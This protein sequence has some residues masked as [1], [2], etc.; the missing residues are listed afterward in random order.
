MSAPAEQQ[1]DPTGLQSLAYRYLPILAWLPAYNRAQLMPD[2]VAALTVWA[3]LVPEAMAYAT[4]AGVPLE[5]GLY[6]AILPLFLYA[7]F[8]TSRQLI[9]G[10]SSTVAILSAATIAPL[11]D[12]TEEF[13]AL[14][15][16]L[17][18]LVGVILVVAG[19]A[20]MGWV[21]QFMAKP[22]LEG[23]VIGLALVVLVGQ[24]DKLV[25][26]DAEGDNFWQEAWDLVNSLGN[27]HLET[28]VIGVGSLVLLFTLA[29]FVP[30][31]PGALITVFLG[32]VISASLNLEDEGVH[33]VGDIPSGLPPFGLP[34]GI[35][36]TDIQNLL[37][38]AFGIVLV[39]YAES[40]A[41]AQSYAT[42]Y[43]YAV[44]PNQ[45]LIALGL[46]NAGA[47][48]SQGF[49]VD[50]SLSRT[51]A[52]DSAGQKTQMSSLINGALVIVTVLALTALFQDLPEAVLGAI[53][54]HAVWHL[55][56][57]KKLR[58]IYNVS[59]AD[60]WLAAICMLGV[61]TFDILA[62]LIIA[63]AVSL[64]VLIYRASRP[65]IPVLGKDPDE[66]VYRS[67]A[68]HPESE[69]YTGLIIF[70]LDAEL[71]FANATYFRDRV[72]EQRATADPPARAILVD[73]E[74]IHDLD[75]TAAEML[76]ELASELADDGIELLFA[77]VHQ[78]VRE[79]MQRSGVEDAVGPDHIYPTIQDGVDDFLTRHPEAGGR[80]RPATR[81]T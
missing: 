42:K 49:V 44:D 47:A 1:A 72:R 76:K 54:V 69:T 22:V 12:G 29:R 58:A 60:F 4:I 17:A 68:R 45:E 55:I 81:D 11:A 57:L 20:R 67:I 7:I 46:S 16:A 3:L 35:S 19:V 5:A 78:T 66:N 71:F 38:G 79:M 13:I 80:D 75:I 34:D 51:A 59:K 52:A 39:A 65:G 63:V 64:L 74:A 10:P 24:A 37:P 40:L 41:I 36:L 25:G 28:A 50:G 48:V 18:I 9:T 73:A 26:V 70:R 62:G 33:I 21:S 77:R 6:A 2:A 23:F 31:A 32:I 14:T 8:G 27:A 61:L 56:D 43:K 15:A 30:R 53:V